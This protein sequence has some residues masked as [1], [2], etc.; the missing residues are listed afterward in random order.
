MRYITATE[1][2][3]NLGYYLELSSTEDIYVTKNKK[4]I[5]VL[6]NSEKHKLVLIEQLSGSFGNVSEDI[7]YDEILKNELLNKYN[8]Y[9]DI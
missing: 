4:I 5:T 3:N 6:T 9:E 7:D 8:A 2:R 1:L